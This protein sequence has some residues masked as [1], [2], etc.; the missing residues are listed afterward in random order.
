MLLH[1]TRTW[2][3]SGNYRIEL[4]HMALIRAAHAPADGHLAPAVGGGGVF[5]KGD[6][7]LDLPDYSSQD[8]P[9]CSPAMGCAV[10]APAS[11]SVLPPSSGSIFYLSWEKSLSASR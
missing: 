6:A 4:R 2:I 8:L 10:T 5:T 3:S 9:D 1:C 11:A 7:G